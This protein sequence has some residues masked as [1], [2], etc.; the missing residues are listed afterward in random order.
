MPDHSL[1]T[2]RI[3]RRIISIDRNTTD[4]IIRRSLM[5]SRKSVGQRTKPWGTLALTG[6]SCEDFSSRTT[7]SPLLLW[8]EE[9]RP[10]IWPEITYNLS[11]W[12][13]Q[14]CQTLSKALDISSA[15]AWVAP[16]LLKALAILSVTTIKKSAVDWEDLKPYILEIKKRF[17]RWSTILLFT[18]FSKTLLI[19]ERTLIG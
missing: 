7:W 12:R 19:T 5:Y 3:E 9:I 18:G 8:K 13:K 1:I 2:L 15:T 17:S 11:L 16:D 4:I 6:Y 10:D 14:V